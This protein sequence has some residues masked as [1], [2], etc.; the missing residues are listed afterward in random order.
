MYDIKKVSSILEILKKTSRK[1]LKDAFRNCDVTGQY[2]CFGSNP[3]RNPHGSDHCGNRSGTWMQIDM[4]EVF[5]F[6]II[7]F[8]LYDGDRRTYTYS[9]KISV[10]G[11]IWTDVAVNRKGKSNQKLELSEITYARYIRMEGQNNRARDGLHI[12]FFNLELK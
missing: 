1:R 9:L 3:F 12:Y 2:I 7:G 4:K 8:R 5:A 10:D 11:K 6:N